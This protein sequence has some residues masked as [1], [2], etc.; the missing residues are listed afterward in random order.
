MILHIIALQAVR[1]C[2]VEETPI[3]DR[4]V[5][6]HAN[7]PLLRTGSHPLLEDEAARA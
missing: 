3:A 5:D 7:R 1:F 6:S 4:D 2:V